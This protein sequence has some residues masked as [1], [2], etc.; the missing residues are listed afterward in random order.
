[1]EVTVRLR[2]TTPSLG[3]VRSP[4]RDTMR[5]DREG[6]IVYLQAWWRAT[7]KFAAHA[8]SRHHKE[9][10]EIQADPLIDGKTSVYKRYYSL[11]GFKEHEAFLDGDE[12][13]ARFMLPN[14]LSI[15]EFHELLEVAGK[16][17]GISPYGFKQ[18]FGRFVVMSIEPI[19]RAHVSI[20]PPFREHDTGHTTDGVH[21][22]AGAAVHEAHPEGRLQ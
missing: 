8:I 12:V 10:E 20:D 17:A 16:Y 2:F 13:V 19:R 9:V 6:K 15:G 4:N 5:R 1:M 21:S 11:D 18:N 3:D 22:G 14:K 7:L